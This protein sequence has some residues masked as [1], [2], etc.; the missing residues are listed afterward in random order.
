VGERIIVGLP[1]AALQMA[2]LLLYGLPL[3]A[4]VLG[5]VAGQTLAGADGWSGE[6]P[7]I[8]GGLLGLF[9][10]LSAARRLGGLSGMRPVMLRCARA[11]APDFVPL[12]ALQSQPKSP[13]EK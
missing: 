11:D 4:L 10:G 12:G 13:S 5:A 8:L 7:A 9:A 1:E 6:L 2:A 3:L